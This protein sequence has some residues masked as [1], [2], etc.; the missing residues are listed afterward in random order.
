MTRAEAAR[1]LCDQ[2]AT[3]V[4]AIAPPG[5]GRWPEAWEIVDSGSM[6]GMPTESTWS[7]GNEPMPKRDVTTG[8][9]AVST[10]S[11]SSS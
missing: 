6:P 2:L 8:N 9:W 4:A 1:K 5:I 7:S 3:D 10:S 11:A